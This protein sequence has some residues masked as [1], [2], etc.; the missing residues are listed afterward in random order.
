MPAFVGGRFSSNAAVSADA[1]RCDPELEPAKLRLFPYKLHVRVSCYVLQHPNDRAGT[2][3]AGSTCG[4]KIAWQQTGLWCT[5]MPLATAL[6]RCIP[7]WCML[8]RN[9]RLHQQR[10]A[11]RAATEHAGRACACCPCLPRHLLQQR[12]RCA[13]ALAQRRQVLQM[14]T[15]LAAQLAML[16]A[17]CQPAAASKLGAGVDNAWESFGGGPPDLFFPDDFEG[18]WQVRFLASAT[19]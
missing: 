16:A 4:C 18:V 14:P 1:H 17:L 12:Q 9:V 8:C 13:H 10:T 19:P 7:S 5:C 3:P 6:R 15:A 11:S 2:L